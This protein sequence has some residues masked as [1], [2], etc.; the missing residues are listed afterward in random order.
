MRLFVGQAIKTQTIANCDSSG[1][2]PIV[3][4]D[5]QVGATSNR[6]IERFVVETEILSIYHTN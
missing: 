6:W 1:I 2:T 5:G 4:D 3:D